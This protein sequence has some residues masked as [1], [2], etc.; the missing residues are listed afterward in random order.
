MALFTRGSL[1]KLCTLP[2]QKRNEVV[3]FPHLVS[4]THD[5]LFAFNGAVLHKACVR[6]H[7]WGAMAMRQKQF[8]H[9]T[10]LPNT[11]R[12]CVL[13][14]NQVENAAQLIATGLLTVDEKHPLYRFNWMEAH[15]RCLSHWDELP[16]LV[17]ELKTFAKSGKWVDFDPQHRAM[18]SLMDVLTAITPGRAETAQL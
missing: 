18:D 13:C 17:Y 2:M 15:K 16:A 5:A 10:I 8:V 14:Q 7:P 11:Q 6:A 12:R 1:C 3:V 9:E 4:N